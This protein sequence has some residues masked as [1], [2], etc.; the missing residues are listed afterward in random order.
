M[1]LYADKC[2]TSNDE[3]SD[4]SNSII[5]DNEMDQEEEEVTPDHM[6]CRIDG[7]N[8][9]SAGDINVT[10][11]YGVSGENVDLGSETAVIST[12]EGSSTEEIMSDND[13]SQHSSGSKKTHVSGVSGENVDMCS[14]NA[15]LSTH[16]SSSTEDMMSDNDSKHSTRLRKKNGDTFHDPGSE[17]TVI[18]THESSSTEDIMSDNDSKHSTRPKKTKW[19]YFS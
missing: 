13:D 5:S 12:H 6:Y 17:T 2:N 16:E 10:R 9:K 14:K 18:S 3:K 1:W 19:G 15:V 7:E 4:T 8:L 11:E